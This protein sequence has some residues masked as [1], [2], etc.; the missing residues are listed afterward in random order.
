[1]WKP[2]I[3]LFLLLFPSVTLAAL[4]FSESFEGTGYENTWTETVDAGNTV[5]E[6][7]TAVTPPTCGSSQ[8]L[9]T[10]TA[11]TNPQ[12]FTV[13]NNGAG[14]NAANYFRFYVLFNNV[15]TAD[16]TTMEIFTLRGVTKTVGV[17]FRYTAGNGRHLLYYRNTGGGFTLH[18]TSSNNLNDNQW[19]RVEGLYDSVGSTWGIRLDGVDVIPSEA[20]TSPRTDT[21][22]IYAGHVSQRTHNMY[23]DLVK[24]STS[25]WIGAET[26]GGAEVGPLRR[27][28]Q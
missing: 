20:I 26:C 15:N 25:G 9:Y 24:W 16:T 23:F 22:Y 6:D 18:A 27:R 13:W 10:D 21:Q 8:V 7:S 3:G 12:A 5:D 14:S 11:G 28:V 1:M 4:P 2:L 19:Y 17:A